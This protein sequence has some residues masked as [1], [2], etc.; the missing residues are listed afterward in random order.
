VDDTMLAQLVKMGQREKVNPN[1][2]DLDA[3][4]NVFQVYLKAEIARRV[5][6]QPKFL[7]DL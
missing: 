2:T 3:Y 6:G 1:P 7:S 5:W 4:K